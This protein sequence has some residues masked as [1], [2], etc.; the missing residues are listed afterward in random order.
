MSELKLKRKECTKTYQWSM[1]QNSGCVQIA[2]A[3]VPGRTSST[4]IARSKSSEHLLGSSEE[5]KSRMCSEGGDSIM[6]IEGQ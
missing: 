1:A 4:G 5:K 3:E 2:A 6:E